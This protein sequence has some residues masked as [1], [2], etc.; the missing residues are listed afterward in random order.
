ML[1]RKSLRDEKA[2]GDRLRAEAAQSRP[3]FSEA[4]HARICRA[5]Q[6][7][8]PDEAGVDRRP[9]G[10]RRG[11]RR[12]LATVA[13]AASLGTA[14]FVWQ[15]YRN[16]YGPDGARPGGLADRAATGGTSLAD[17]PDFH[18]ELYAVTG[19][20]ATMPEKIDALID[21]AVATQQWTDLGD[22]A[23][24]TVRMLADRLPFDLASSL[25]L[26]EAPASP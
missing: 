1:N 14:M 18:V 21:S 8:R 19:F 11:P 3:D 26:N 15:A 17:A 16:G 4:L 9:A 25:T 12:T 6:H 24:L 2:L 13:V 20:A 22:D 7:C 5:V 23:R 10:S